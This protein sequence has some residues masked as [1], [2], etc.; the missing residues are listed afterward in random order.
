MKTKR[1][2]IFISVI[3]PIYNME[4]YLY[5]CMDKLLNQTWE[6]YEI[7][8]VNDGSQD[9]SSELCE[10]YQLQCPKLVKVI[11]K[12]NGGLSSARNAGINVAKGNFVIFPDPDDWVEE[13]YLEEFVNV[14]TQYDVDLVC[15]GYYV[16]HENGTSVDIK[17][18]DTLYCKGKEARKYLLLPPRMS[19]FAWNKLYRLSIIKENK[20]TF[21]DDVGT[22]EDLDFA[23]RYM[24]CC[25]Y[26]YY[27]PKIKVYHY[28]Q[29]AEG[30][31]R[32]KFGYKKIEALNTYKKIIKENENDDLLANAAKVEIC[33][34][35][36][37]LFRAYYKSKVNDKNVLKYLRTEIKKYFCLVI[38]SKYISNKEKIKAI[39]SYSWM[40]VFWLLKEG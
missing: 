16:E 9:A 30:A 8:L 12:E 3:V 40:E 24:G 7:I 33:M 36:L 22:T 25:S 32:T 19:G 26:V 18:N 10:K 1:D 14:Q 34:N 29:S 37:F 4:K 2:D 5:R 38:L 39:I 13:K 17:G 31:T 15:L 20:L 11:H 23:Y 35:A 27:D 28:Y 6:R 21:L